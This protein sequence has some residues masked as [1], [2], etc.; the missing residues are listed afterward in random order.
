MF[1]FDGN[2]K[3]MGFVSVENKQEKKKK[4]SLTW[5]WNLWGRIRQRNLHNRFS[6]NY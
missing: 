3:C 6:K 5:Q 2:E 1:Q 4:G